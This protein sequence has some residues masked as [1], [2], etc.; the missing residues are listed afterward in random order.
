MATQTI[1]VAH[2]VTDHAT[3]FR[4]YALPY[5]MRPGQRPN[6][7]R[8]EYRKDWKEIGLL[9]SLGRIVCMEPEYRQFFEGMSPYSGMHFEAE[10]PDPAS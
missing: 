5:R 10:M 7:I 8:L 4:I 6:D 3:Q 9:N 1:Y 2:G